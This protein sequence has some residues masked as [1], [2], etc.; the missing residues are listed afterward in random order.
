MVHPIL[1]SPKI[2]APIA[3]GLGAIAGALCRYACGQL[4]AGLADA[5][6]FPLG[7]LFINLLGCF[8]MGFAS[9]LIVRRFAS[10]P[11]LA[12]LVQ[13]GFLGSYTTFSTYELEM[14]DLLY[15]GQIQASLIYG[16]GSPL[17]GLLCLGLGIVLANMVAP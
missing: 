10:K 16:L 2:H 9:T 14:A 5:I 6:Q 4:L 8:L 17:L 1:S 13:T 3:V 7:T 15:Q 12:L 11:E